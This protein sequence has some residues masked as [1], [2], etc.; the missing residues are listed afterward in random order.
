VEYRAIELVKAPEHGDGVLHVVRVDPKRARLELHAASAG[1]GENRTAG[2]W[3][4]KLDALAV[5]NAGMYE[6]DF[7]THTGYLRIGKHENNPRWVGAYK[8]A[9]VLGP[10]RAARILD[11]K[12]QADLPKGATAAAQNLRLIAGPGKNVWAENHRAWSE[13]ALAMDT[14]GRILLLFSR[15]PLSMR[16]FNRRILAAG[17]GVTHAQHLEGGPEASLSL[18]SEAVSFDLS[19]SYETGFNERDDNHHQ[20]VLPNVIVVR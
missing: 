4:E 8:S 7:R 17:L 1:D 18:R 19:G 10:G 5:I 16:H 9:L 3:A 11:V 13:A 20:W 15:T 14:K 2:Q 12:R 6:T